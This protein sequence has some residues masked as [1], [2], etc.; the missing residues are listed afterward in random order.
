MSWTHA[1]VPLP[2]DTLLEIA[3]ANDLVNYIV[4]LRAATRCPALTKS[5][6]RAGVGRSVRG[7]A[8]LQHV[9][10]HSQKG[11]VRQAA[12]AGRGGARHA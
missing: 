1:T 2:G 5:P 6:A 8:C 11:I 12:R 9:P 7:H 3:Q 10:L 4:Y